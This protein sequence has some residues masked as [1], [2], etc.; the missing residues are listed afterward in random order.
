ER[1]EVWLRAASRAAPVAARAIGCVGCGSASGGP[2]AW[3]DPQ[4]PPSG[5]QA[6]RIPSG[7]ELPHPSQWR[8]VH[9]DRGTATAALTDA[10]GRYLGYLNV[11]PQQGDETLANWSSFRPAHNVEEGD[12]G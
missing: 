7:A 10:H 1:P 3:L 9:G 5:W 11:T 12:H 8:I 4:P 2:F 6:A